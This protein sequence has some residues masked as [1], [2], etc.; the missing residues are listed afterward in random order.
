MRRIIFT[1]PFIAATPAFAH[2]GHIGEIAGHSHWLAAGAMGAA[3]LIALWRA[4]K[5]AQEAETETEITPEET[6][7]SDEAEA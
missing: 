2:A 7:N 3:A 5:A 6:E 4:V 1:L